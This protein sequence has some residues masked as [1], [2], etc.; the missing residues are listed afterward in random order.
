MGYDSKQRPDPA[1]SGPVFSLSSHHQANDVLWV[2]QA[3]RQHL[4][5]ASCLP[6]APAAP[7]RLEKHP[8]TRG[9]RASLI[10]V[11][12]P[13]LRT[14]FVHFGRGCHAKVCICGRGPGKWGK[15]PA[16]KAA[17][18]LSSL[19]R[20]GSPVTTPTPASQDLRPPP[21][22]SKRTCQPAP[23]KDPTHPAAPHSAR[24]LI[25]WR[26][27][28]LTSAQAAARRRADLSTNQSQGAPVREARLSANPKREPEK[29][30]PNRSWVG[31]RGHPSTVKADRCHL[32]NPASWAGPTGLSSAGPPGVTLGLPASAP[33]AALRREESGHA[34]S[35]RSAFCCDAEAP[36]G[37][38][39]RTWGIGGS[40]VGGGGRYEVLG[41]EVLVIMSSPVRT[42][43]LETRA[44]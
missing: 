39:R 3:P 29:G 19:S 10:C 4:V 17:R 6:A 13:V 8:R 27:A 1:C 24:T 9:F 15:P 30:V 23:R 14:S 43:Q 25:G 7:S 26:R 20:L 18:N 34:R 28:G 44:D 31:G 35:P 2:P 42:V 5:P 41:P 32:D 11:L 36:D 21:A 16:D 37:A 33:G 38:A 40:P 22:A 12:E